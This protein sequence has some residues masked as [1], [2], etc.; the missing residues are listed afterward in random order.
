MLQS[1][2]LHSLAQSKWHL[3]RN[4]TLLNLANWPWRQVFQPPI[5]TLQTNTMNRFHPLFS[6][7][8]NYKK[9]TWD[10]LRPF[11]RS[12]AVTGTVNRAY[13]WLRLVLGESRLRETVRAQERF[14]SNP[15]RKQRKR[16][17]RDW[18]MYSDQVQRRVRL[19][20]HLQQRTREE[21]ESYRDL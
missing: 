12:V 14:E 4:P 10:S 3:L 19:A 11:G 2:R 21:K 7:V 18:R 17:E 6:Q 20:L 13:Y 9:H 5:F 16:K 8:R 15:V 1:S